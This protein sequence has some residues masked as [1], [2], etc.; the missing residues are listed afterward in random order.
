[1]ADRRRPATVLGLACLLLVGCHKDD[2]KGRADLGSAAD[3]GLGPTHVAIGATTGSLGVDFTV[4]VDGQGAS[5]LGAVKL[6]SGAG[7]VTFDGKTLPAFAHERQAWPDQGYTL[8]QTIAAD[9]TALYVLWLYCTA[10]DKL[11][12]AYFEGTDG[13]AMSYEDTTGTCRGTTTASTVSVGLPAL[14]LDVALAQGFAATAPRLAVNDGQPGQFGFDSTDT[15]LL[16]FEVVDCTACGQ[17]SWYELHSILRDDATHQASFAIF[18]FWPSKPSDIHVTYSLTLP[19]LTDPVGT[20]TSA[21]RGATRRQRS[22]GRRPRRRAC[23]GCGRR[24]AE[25]CRR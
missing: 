4:S 23:R 17:V 24:A 1:M 5:R 8:Y 18:Y 13:T 16:P 9:E 20:A 7:T 12:Y 15:V 6:Q 10:D 22:D 14:A 25:S 19:S 3:L 21:D 2:N 11:V